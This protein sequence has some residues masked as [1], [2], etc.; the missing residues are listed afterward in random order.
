[1]SPPDI[2]CW[3]LWSDR[4][5]KWLRDDYDRLDWKSREEA[6]RHADELNPIS[7]YGDWR[8]VRV[9]ETVVEE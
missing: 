5:R 1:V 7:I 9:R 2:D 6:Q 3:R 4:A 8:P